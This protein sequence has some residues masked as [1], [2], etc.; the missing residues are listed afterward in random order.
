MSIIFIAVYFMFKFPWARESESAVSTLGTGQMFDKE[1]NRCS[2]VLSCAKG[3]L[4]M[5]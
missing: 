2:K 1:E 5:P 4:S 3:G